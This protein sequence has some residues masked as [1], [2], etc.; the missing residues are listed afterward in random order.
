MNGRLVIFFGAITLFLA[1]T[2]P[3]FAVEKAK[4]VGSRQ[5]EATYT[6]NYSKD[7]KAILD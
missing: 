7:G 1:I 5:N 3:A 2:L 4:T 6:L